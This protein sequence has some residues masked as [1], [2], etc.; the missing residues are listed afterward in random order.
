VRNDGRAAV[1]LGDC[2]EA[3]REGEFHDLTPA[4]AEIAGLDEHAARAQIA[5]AAKATHTP[6]QQDVDRRAGTMTRR[7]S[8]L[9]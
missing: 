8:S 4:Q 5:R 2:P 7:E 1:D 3:D 9:H 6:G